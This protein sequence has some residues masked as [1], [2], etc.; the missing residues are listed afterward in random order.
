MN[1]AYFN[2]NLKSGDNY[3]LSINVT[4]YKKRYKSTISYLVH[5]PYLPWKILEKT[6]FMKP[7]IKINVIVPMYNVTPVVIKN[8]KQLSSDDVQIYFIINNLDE[9]SANKLRE[10]KNS[11]VIRSKLSPVKT[12]VDKIPENDL[13][14]LMDNNIQIDRVVIDNVYRRTIKNNSIY[15]PIVVKDNRW[16]L[17]DVNIYAIYKSDYVKT[18][19]ETGV[20]MLKDERVQLK[21]TRIT[22]SHLIHC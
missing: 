16:A 1:Y 15:L 8:Y 22:E 10:I 21:K 4:D 7:L 17:E 18:P 2:K 14:L 12:V 11:Q 9:E 5:T 20:E 19:L 6:L 3:F 13:I